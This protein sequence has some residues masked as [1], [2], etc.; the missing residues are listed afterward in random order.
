[1]STCPEGFYYGG[2]AVG[3]LPV[4]PA[5]PG[6]PKRA[7]RPIAE[8]SLLKKLEPKRAKLPPPRGK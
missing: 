8:H 6:W 7:K 3:C 1:M 2:P 5:P 4:P